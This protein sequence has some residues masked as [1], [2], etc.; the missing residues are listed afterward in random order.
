MDIAIPIYDRLTALDAVGPYDVLSRIPDAT[1][2]FIADEPG[3]KRTENGMLALVADRALEELPEP[4]VVVVPGGFGTRALLE[5]ERIVGW[6][7]HA[8]EGSRYTT[9]VCTGALLLGAAGVLDGLEATTHWAELETLERFGAR[10]S[11][12]RVI[13]QG[14]V[15]TAAGVSSGIDMALLLAARLAGDEVAKA[16][17]LAIE[18]DPE[19]PFDSGS[20]AKARPETVE[21]VR[22]VVEAGVRGG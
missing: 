14:K 2:S 1:V 20:T 8:H 18:Y 5:D 21:L 4:E 7:R 22:N 17:Q 6:I 3:P 12:R 13:E 19:P 15:I 16:I 9:S 10:P 11:S